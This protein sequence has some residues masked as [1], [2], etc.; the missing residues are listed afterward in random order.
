MTD[1]SREGLVKRKRGFGTIVVE[2]NAPK[3]ASS[4]YIGIFLPMLKDER[5]ELSPNESPTWSM[6]FYGAMRACAERG[7]TLIP[8][9]DSG[10]PWEK[11]CVTHNLSGILIPGGRIGIVESFLRSGI[12]SN[13]QCVMIDRSIDFE[14]VNYVEE[15]SSESIA[16]GITGLLKKGHDRI[17]AVGEDSRARSVLNFFDG[18]RMALTTT[19]RYSTSLVKRVCNG[20][21][22]EYDRLI[23]E[24]L[25]NAPPSL[26]VVFNK[27][28]L[29]G[30]IMALKRRQVSIPQDVSIV[31]IYSESTNKENGVCVT[32]L[33]S[34]EKYNFGATAANAL[35]NLLEKRA[36]EPLRINL[37]LKFINGETFRV[38]S[39]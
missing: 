3:N 31:L 32:S 19:G 34:P 5:S 28:L 23:G 15:F 6:I 25:S 30:V 24:L 7:Y 13:I 27:R 18:Y 29:E 12:R 2:K 1:L 33:V 35:M 4:K 14:S 36:E 10:T 38:L 9:P 39:E 11:L 21:Q 22:E 20:T 37:E 26:I 8:I 17:A 16:T